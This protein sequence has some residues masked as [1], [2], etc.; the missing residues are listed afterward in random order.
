MW[1]KEL[2]VPAKTIWKDGSMELEVSFGLGELSNIEFPHSGAVRNQSTW[3]NWSHLTN[4][5]HSP[6]HQRYASRHGVDRA[7]F[8]C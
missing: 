4:L 2:S 7:R 6:G 5:R 8:F 3:Y 1:G